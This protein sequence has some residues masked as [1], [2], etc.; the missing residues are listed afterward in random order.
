VHFASLDFLIFLPLTLIIYWA[1]APKYRNSVLLVSSLVFYASWRVSY[2]P[3]LLVVVLFAWLSGLFLQ[4]TRTLGGKRVLTLSVVGLLVPLVIVKYQGW[5]AESASAL[6]LMLGIHYDIPQVDVELPLGISFFTFQVVA[7][8]VDVYRGSEAEKSP[9]RFIT[10]VTFFPQLISGPIVRSKDLLPQLSSPLWLKRGDVGSGLFRIG[11]GMVKKLIIADTLKVGIVTPVFFDPSSFT[12]LEVLIALY[13][14]TLQIYCDFSGYTDIALGAAILFGI[15]LPEN[16][17]RPYKAASVAEFWRRWHIT[18]SDWVRDY[19]YFPLGGSRVTVE[20]KVY[21]NIIVTLV[22]IGLWHRASW[23]LVVYGLL[24]GCAVSVNRWRRKRSVSTDRP[25]GL[26]LW[27]RVA[28]TFHFIVFARILFRAENFATAQDI[29]QSVSHQSMLLPRFSATAMAILFAGYALH[30]SPREWID[31]VG[32][33]FA[34]SGP[35][36]WAVG[37]GAVGALGMLFGSGQMLAFE[38][39]QF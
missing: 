6:L 5:L 4:K 11:S 25:V 24:H 19:V 15:R 23:M 20:W 2:L 26:A 39:Y 10:F 34:I 27:W 16:F 30:F 22:V 29:L 32:D 28:L 38:Y 1:V 21:R 33:R 37:L 31:S 18:L 36:L 7:Y 14:Y 13:A 8:V 9:W 12:G 17:R 3:L 35:G